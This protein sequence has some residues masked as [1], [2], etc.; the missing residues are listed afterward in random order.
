MEN[1]D[2]F[3]IV[4]VVSGILL[5]MVAI[6]FWRSIS[7]A[8]KRSKALR[9]QAEQAELQEAAKVAN[10]QNLEKRIMADFS[11]KK[12]ARVRD[13]NGRFVKNSSKNG[14]YQNKV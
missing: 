5:L 7:N 6:S 2:E 10:K 1:M 11:T 9:E 4:C 3:L 14:T 8:S 13:K 12:P